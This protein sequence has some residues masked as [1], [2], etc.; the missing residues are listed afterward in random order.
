[1]LINTKVNVAKTRAWIKPTNISRPINGKG[2]MSGIKKAITASRTS[3]AKMLPN[4]LKAKDMIFANSLRSSR[5]PTKKLIGFE[6]SK[7][8]L[9]YLK[10]YQFPNTQFFHE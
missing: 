4:N 10:L 1:M 9:K 7:N 5:K 3:P 8:F 2:T 6:R